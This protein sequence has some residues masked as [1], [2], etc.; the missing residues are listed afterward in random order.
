MKLVIRV[1]VY[2]DKGVLNTYDSIKF[3]GKEAEKMQEVVN[4][5]E[6]LQLFSFSH[7]GEGDVWEVFFNR[8]MLDRSI[9]CCKTWDENEDT[10]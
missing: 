9:V 1:Q 7:Q 10:D 4:D 5:I 8:P 6:N 2:G 3:E